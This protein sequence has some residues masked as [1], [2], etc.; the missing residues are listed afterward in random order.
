M[1]RGKLGRAIFTIF[2]YKTAVVSLSIILAL[3]AIS[4]YAVVTVPYSRAVEMWNSIEYWQELPK[5]ALPSWINIFS[6][7]KLPESIIINS[8]SDNV[9]R[10]ITQFGGMVNVTFTI[11]FNYSYDDFPSEIVMKFDVA[12]IT[13][14][15]ELSVLWVKPSGSIVELTR[16]PIERPSSYLYY[17]SQDTSLIKRYRSMIVSRY[18]REPDY[19]LVPEVFLFAKEDVSILNKT[20]LSVDKGEYNIII[21]SIF[22]EQNVSINFKIYIYGKVYGLFG[23]DDRRRDLTLAIIWGAPLALSFGLV[24]SLTIALAQM[25][26][27]A[28]SVW[29]GGFIDYLIQRIVEIDMVLPFLPILI[30]IAVIYRLDIWILLAVIIVLFTFGGGIKWYR[31]YFMSLKSAAYIEAAKAYGA[32]DMRIILRYMVPRIIPIIVPTLISSVPYFVFLEA[33]LAILGVGGGLK[34]APTWGRV[35]D[36]AVSAGA[37]YRGYYHWVLFPSMMLVIT[38]VA[39]AL[40]GFTLERIFNPKLREF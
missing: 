4:I 19:A 26:I 15:G 37:L 28:I 16:I 20:S 25:V 1:V 13:K 33:A 38:S 34:V 30:M 7:K 2:R 29:Y 8:Y 36:D 6:P 14:S 31:A 9:E 10:K 5:L 18:G 3:L 35:L 27:A 40:L 32:S 17:V 22:F 23:T 21:S 24:A 39:F 12:N 11:R